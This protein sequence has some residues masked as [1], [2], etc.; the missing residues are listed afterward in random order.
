MR[1]ASKFYRELRAQSDFHLW[2]VRQCID[3]LHTQLLCYVDDL[4]YWIVEHVF[5]CLLGT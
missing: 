3:A 1:Y 2:F 4:E 5:V